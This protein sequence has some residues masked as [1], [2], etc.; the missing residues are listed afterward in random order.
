MS[1]SNIECTYSIVGRPIRVY[2]HMCMFE[3]WFFVHHTG[4]Y[5]NDAP[6]RACDHHT[7]HLTFDF[8][9]IFERLDKG[10]CR[11]YRYCFT[12][13]FRQRTYH[14]VNASIQNFAIAKMCLFG[15]CAHIEHD[16]RTHLPIKGGSHAYDIQMTFYIKYTIDK[17]SNVTQHMRT[18]ATANYTLGA[19]ASLTH[20]EY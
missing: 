17:S 3:E 4:I 19:L 20:A 18:I 12:L 8:C 14:K 2:V 1:H 6:I 9:G 11:H 13:P 10:L 15:A 16:Q 7:A 5:F